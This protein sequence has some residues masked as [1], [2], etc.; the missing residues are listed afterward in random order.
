MLGRN[1]NFQTKYKHKYKDISIKVF[2]FFFSVYN[3]DIFFLYG[4]NIVQILN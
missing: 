4:L 2:V 1:D 3:E